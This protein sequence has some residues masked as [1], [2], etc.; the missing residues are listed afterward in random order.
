MEKEKKSLDLYCAK[1][2]HFQ[3]RTMLNFTKVS[4]KQGLFLVLVNG[5]N[6]KS[7]KMQNSAN[8]TLISE[9]REKYGFSQEEMARLLDINRGQL[10]HLEIR[11]R[12]L[13]VEAEEKFMALTNGVNAQKEETGVRNFASDEQKRNLFV[14]KSE[15]D[16]IA[17][18]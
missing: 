1:I 9:F 2:K 15:G 6:T 16:L 14:R 17:M 3:N 10:S 7:N 12:H 4:W 5:G 11:G 13:P 18:R 8:L